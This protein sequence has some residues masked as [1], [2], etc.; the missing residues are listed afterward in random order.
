METSKISASS[1][2]E[3]ASLFTRLGFTAALLDGVNVAALGLMAGVTLII[4]RAAV[5]DIPTVILALLTAVLLFRYKISTIWLVLG[6]AIIGL[7]L[8][9]YSLS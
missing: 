5:I 6:A 9:L 7:L 8:S 1:L 3:L 2:G 4:G